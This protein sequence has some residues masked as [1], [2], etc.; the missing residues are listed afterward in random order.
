MRAS[1]I[2]PTSSSQMTKTSKTKQKPAKPTLVKRVRSRQKGL[3]ARRPHRSFR[4]TRRRDYIRPL[5]LSGYFAFNRKVW[6]ILWANRKLFGLLAVV[7][8]LLA[9]M[10]VGMASQDN[11]L[12]VTDLLKETS[13]QAFDGDWGKLGEATLLF[14]T[15]ISGGI[16]DAMTEA[17]QIYAVLIIMIAWLSTVWL[18]RNILANRQVKLRDGLYNS[19]APLFSTFLVFLLIVV[20]SLPLAL[21]FFGYSAAE[22]TGLLAGGVEAMLFWLAAGLLTL[23]SVYWLAGSFLALVAVTLPGMYPMQAIKVAGD[24]VV[25]RRVKIILRML[26]LMLGIALVWVL[27]LVP[28]IMLDTWAKTVWPAIE[29]VPIVPLIMLALSSL[30]VVW[31]ASYVY[32]LYREIIDNDEAATT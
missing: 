11:Y 10:I 29:W 23:L 16:N 3:L 13:G 9:G 19:G 25:G 26:W 27:I 30:T 32:L 22:S 4:L 5:K 8:G 20:Q 17:Q 1:G 12:A 28:L 14:V 7:Y 15:I 21:V 2:T 6:R 24:L 31:T 18:L